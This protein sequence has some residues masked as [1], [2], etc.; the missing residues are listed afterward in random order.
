MIMAV[1]IGLI[2]S[3]I[4]RG[5]RSEGSG[6]RIITSGVASYGALGH[7]ALLDQLCNAIYCPPRALAYCRF[8]GHGVFETLYVQ[9]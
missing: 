4:G 6:H 7:V 8:A 9:C 3:T 5:Q 1:G 2:V